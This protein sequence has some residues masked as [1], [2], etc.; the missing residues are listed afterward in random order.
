M[1]SIRFGS[2]PLLLFL[3]LLI[4]AL[5]SLAIPATLQGR[6]VG[7]ADGDTVTILTPER[8][9]VRIR[10][11]QIDAPEKAQPFGQ[12]SKQS[13]SDL[14]FGTEVRVRVETT[15]RY[16]RTVGRVFQD[17][18]DV[19]LEQVKRGMAWAYRQYLTDKIFLEVEHAAKAAKIGLW[20]D[21]NPTPPWEFRHSE[22]DPGRPFGSAQSLPKTRSGDTPDL[23]DFPHKESAGQLPRSDATVP[24]E[25]KCEAKRYCGQM[26]SCQEARFYLT[27]CGVRSLD[28]D[29][30]GIPCESLCRG[31]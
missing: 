19:N 3:L 6:V 30:D 11:G 17:N 26:I 18:V 1:K 24:A 23:G 25:F 7:V 28:G 14:I 13:L 31:R 12:R 5:P 2:I 29:G 27:Q 15:D 16:G 10:L 9:Q 4:F 20:S 22:R 21:P 8:Q